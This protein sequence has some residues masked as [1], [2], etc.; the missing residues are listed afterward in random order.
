MFVHAV[1]RKPDTMSSS[2]P[3][4][5]EHRLHGYRPRETG[6]GEVV[7]ESASEPFSPGSSSSDRSPPRS[8]AIEC[9]VTFTTSP[10]LS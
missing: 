9:V 5:G 2:N 8:T 6:Y 1:L 4:T 3:T 7:C 10:R